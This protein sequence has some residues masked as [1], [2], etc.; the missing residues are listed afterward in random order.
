[1][2]GPTHEISPESRP[3]IASLSQ[4]DREQRQAALHDI[5]YTYCI[6]C[7]YSQIYEN[8]HRLCNCQETE[9]LHNNIVTHEQFNDRVEHCKKIIASWPQWKRDG[10]KE[11]QKPFNIDMD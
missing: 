3:I 2:L 11:Y 8:E 1:M 10:L 5:V 7:G 4:L 6:H 9:Q